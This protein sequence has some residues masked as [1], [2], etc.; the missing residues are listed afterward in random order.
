MK[1]TRV[2]DNAQLVDAF[3]RSKIG[4]KFYVVSLGAMDKRS[5]QNRVYACATVAKKQLAMRKFRD[6]W[7]ATVIE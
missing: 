3:T 2:F 5:E 7:K 6:G 4:D 1:R